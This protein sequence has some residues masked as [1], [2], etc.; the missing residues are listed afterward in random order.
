MRVKVCEYCGSKF[1]TKRSHKKT[2]TNACKSALYR[3]NNPAYDRRYDSS[4]NKGMV[5]R[6]REAYRAIKR[7]CE[8]S[9]T[10]SYKWYGAKGIKCLF[11]F[12]QFRSVYFGEDCCSICLVKLDDKDRRTKHGRTIDRIDPSGHYEIDN[13]RVVCMS[14]NTLRSSRRKKNGRIST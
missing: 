9:K 11:S 2:C 14:C 12:E 6:G 5:L 13:C 4:R 8:D 7:R 1:E 10:A 3:R